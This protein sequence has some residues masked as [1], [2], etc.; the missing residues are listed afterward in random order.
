MKH[1][2]ARIMKQMVQACDYTKKLEEEKKTENLIESKKS[3]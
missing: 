3:E 1:F 2:S